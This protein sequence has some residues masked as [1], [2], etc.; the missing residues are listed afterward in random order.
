MMN[1]KVLFVRDWV[2]RGKIQLYQCL[3]VGQCAANLLP[4]PSPTPMLRPLLPLS[5][6]LSI[7][8]Y[9]ILPVQGLH[10][11]L[12][13]NEKRCFIEEV[14]SN[15][16]VE[17]HYRAVE[18][19][20]KEQKYVADPDLGIHIEVHEEET[21]ELVTQTK[22]PSEG[23]FTFTSHDSGDHSVC[24]STNYTSWFSTTHIRLYLDMAVGSSKPDAE[25][26]RTHVSELAAKVRDLNNKLEDIRREQ[27]YQRERE[28]D[29]R[30]LSEATNSKAVWYSV[31]QIIVLVATCAWQL[32][33][34]K[35]RLIPCFAR[36]T[37][38]CRTEIL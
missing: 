19:S 38:E 7:L 23:K 28:A 30:D 14:P 27:Q 15:T 25:H 9:S 29:Y 21:G 8:F 34:L 1:C 24:L 13:A 11:Y 12:D 17:G 36:D 22:G 3:S 10:F 35:V 16:I 26:D 32:Q 20:E 18:W 33:H 5:F 4:R 6:L 31:V 2:L 37:T